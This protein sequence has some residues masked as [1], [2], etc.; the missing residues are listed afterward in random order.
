MKVFH[1]ELRS[2][3]RTTTCGGPYGAG[4]V[5]RRFEGVPVA[6]RLQ[7]GGMGQRGALSPYDEPVIDWRER[8][9]D[10]VVGTHRPGRLWVCPNCHEV[11]SGERC[12]T[13]NFRGG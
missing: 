10:P 1:D 6:E 9:P 7:N 13:C 2:V 12:P 8:I 11:R 5:S 4:P 3:V